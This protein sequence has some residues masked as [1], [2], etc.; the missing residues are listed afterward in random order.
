MSGEV[1]LVE[2]TAERYRIGGLSSDDSCAS[3][4]VEVVNWHAGGTAKQSSERG[5]E[6]RARVHPTEKTPQVIPKR[7][8]VAATLAL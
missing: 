4:P 3:E 5:G 2:T 1:V 7:A 8:F 6:L